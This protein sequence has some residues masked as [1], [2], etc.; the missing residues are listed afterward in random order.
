MTSTIPESKRDTPAHASELEAR[1]AILSEVGEALSRQLTLSQVAD[2]VGQRLHDAFP[3]VGLFV[4]LY[5]KSTNMVSFPF[6]VESSGKRYVSG[7]PMA[8]DTGLTGHVIQTRR[9]VRKSSLQEMQAA[10]A[11]DIGGMV[12]RSWLGVPMLSD[13]NVIGTVTLES[14]REDAFSDADVQLVTTMAGTAAVA[15]RNAQLFA[16]TTQ[17]NA[18]L[19]V[20]NEIGDAL[21][22]QLDFAGITEAVGER[23]RQIFEV[24]TVLILFHDQDTDHFTFPYMVDQGQRLELEPLPV[25]GLSAIVLRERRPLRLNTLAEAEEHGAVHTGKQ[26]AE[27]WLGVPVLAGDRVL[28]VIAIDRLPTHAFTESD[29]RLLSTIASSMGVA[30]ENARLFDETKHLLSETEQR[31]AELAVINEIGDALSKQLDFQGI[32]DAV[33]DKILE[34]LNSNDLVI[35]ILDPATELVSFPYYMDAGAKVQ[36]P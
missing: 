23:I 22:R 33:G 7:G 30:L 17:R 18:E 27:S 15:L 9:P 31:N 36:A 26:D 24:T 16:E 28:G 34:I 32:V 11:I 19:A 13:G 3:G 20:I 2:L 21:A 6:E 14:E 25:R 29:E 12:T 4:S 10:G 1:L 8:A 35:G 5:D